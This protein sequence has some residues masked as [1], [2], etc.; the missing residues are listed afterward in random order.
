VTQS[1][2]K[3]FSPTV[4][5]PP[6]PSHGLA[7][8]FP[9]YVLPSLKGIFQNVVTIGI[10]YVHGV[11]Y[12]C[13]TVRFGWADATSNGHSGS[14]QACHRDLSAP[15]AFRLFVGYIPECLKQHT[16]AKRMSDQDDFLVRIKL[17]EQLA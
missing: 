7:F 10:Q 13:R 8:V 9:S 11:S 12:D 6:I 17:G 4:D 2:I 3:W 1:R 16:A 5:G 14:E 15:S